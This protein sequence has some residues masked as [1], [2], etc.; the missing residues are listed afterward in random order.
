MTLMHLDSFQQ[1]TTRW[2]GRRNAG[3]SGH[4]DHSVC[5]FAPAA[6]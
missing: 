1:W 3:G 4:R 5:A 6:V 2:E